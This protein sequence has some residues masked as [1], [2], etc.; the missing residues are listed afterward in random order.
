MTTLSKKE[1]AQKD[2]AEMREALSKH[3]EKQRLMHVAFMGK[4]EEIEGSEYVQ[5]ILSECSRLV[6]DIYKRA[7]EV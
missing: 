1:I 2:L 7:G 3:T 6:N 5:E 4:I